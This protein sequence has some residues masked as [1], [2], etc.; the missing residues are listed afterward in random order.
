[1]VQKR[2]VLF[3]HGLNVKASYGV[4]SSIGKNIA[5]RQIVSLYPARNSSPDFSFKYSNTR[6]IIL[7]INKTRAGFPPDVFC[8]LIHF[9]LI[10]SVKKKLSIPTV[11][12]N[13]FGFH[14]KES[15][16]L[17]DVAYNRPATANSSSII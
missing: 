5:L 16:V 9:D 13:M 15:K 10:K 2:R 11:R 14:E 12:M 3:H 6:D 4:S 7:K 1:M 17:A 8:N